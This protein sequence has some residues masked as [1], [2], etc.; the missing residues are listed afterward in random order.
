MAK[1]RPAAVRTPLKEIGDKM[2]GRT[3]GMTVSRRHAVV[4]LDKSRLASSP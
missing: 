1:I 3:L 2:A 4:R